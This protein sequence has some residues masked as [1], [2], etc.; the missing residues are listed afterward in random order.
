MNFLKHL[1]F[2]Y[3]RLSMKGQNSFKGFIK[4]IFIFLSKANQSLMGLEWHEGE[5]IFGSTFHLNVYIWNLCRIN[6]SH[7]HV[8]E[9]STTQGLIWELYSTDTEKVKQGCESLCCRH[10]VLEYELLPLNRWRGL[11]STGASHHPPDRPSCP[12]SSRCAGLPEPWPEQRTRT[13]SSSPPPLCCKD[14]QNSLLWKHWALRVGL[15][16]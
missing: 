16:D 5:Y 10:M 11:G 15:H 3:N 4:N 9:L 1:K 6:D 12:S 7:D 13:G 2:W 8:E 14:T